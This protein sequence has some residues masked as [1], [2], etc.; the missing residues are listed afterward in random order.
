MTISDELFVFVCWQI[1]SI[2]KEY[3]LDLDSYKKVCQILEAEFK[4]GLGKASNAESVIKMFPTYVRSLPD[5]T[6]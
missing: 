5:G 2:V 4:K 3:N 6:G 1:E